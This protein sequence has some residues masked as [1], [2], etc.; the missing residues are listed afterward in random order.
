MP[1]LQFRSALTSPGLPYLGGISGFE[2]V[3]LSTEAILYAGSKAYGAI[4][5]FTLRE[6]G[7]AQ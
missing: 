1:K 4:T 2:L 7:T 5:G 3:F 6:G